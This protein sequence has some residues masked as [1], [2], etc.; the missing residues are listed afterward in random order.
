[1]TKHIQIDYNG[2]LRKFGERA[3]TSGLPV[4]VFIKY[5]RDKSNDRRFDK[6]TSRNGKVAGYLLASVLSIGAGVGL[7]NKEADKDY[8]EV[9]TVPTTNVVAVE[10]DTLWELQSREGA[11]G[12]KDLG[13]TVYDASKLNGGSNIQPGQ[14]VHLIDGPKDPNK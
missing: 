8:S 3:E 6:K 1:M 5:T 14:V 9:P 11:S 10:G 7:L 2:D 13:E 4:D 12:G